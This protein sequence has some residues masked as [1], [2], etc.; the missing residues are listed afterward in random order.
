MAI[1]PARLSL[2]TFPQSWSGTALTVRFVCLPKGD[3][4]QPLRAGLPA[5][6]AANLV[7][8]ARLVGGLDTLPL[9]VDAVPVG[10]LALQDPPAGKAALFAELRN[11]F[12]IVPPAPPP[13]GGRPEPVF[14]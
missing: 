9:S 3:P 6:A 5:F 7:L 2:L 4:E 12:S 13:I 8:E 10:P 11:H 1:A 14:R